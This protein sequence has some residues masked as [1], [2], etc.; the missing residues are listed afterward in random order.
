MI[1]GEITGRFFFGK[2]FGDKKIN[3]IPLTACMQDYLA[4]AMDDTISATSVLFG[5]DFSKLNLLPRHRKMNKISKDLRSIF[6]EMIKE[7][8]EN[9]KKENNLLSTYLNHI[10][11]M[12]D[13]DAQLTH[14]EIVGEFLGIF[15]AGTDT[16]LDYL[17]PLQTPRSLCKGEGRGR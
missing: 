12:K 14:N 6:K 15:A 16:T 17:L 4:Q 2:N 10:Q 1:T 8:E 9:P 3:R 11:S 7:A 13:E 5:P